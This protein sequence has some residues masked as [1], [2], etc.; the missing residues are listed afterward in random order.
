MKI[1]KIA[2]LAMLAGASAR[3]DELQPNA[4]RTVTVCLEKSA[5]RDTISF[6]RL[7]ASKMFA[8]IG[9]TIQWNLKPDGC[10]AQG[11]LLRLSRSNPGDFHPGTLA[12]TQLDE[13]ARITI[14]YG[15]ISERNDKVPVRTLEAHVL[16]HE[17]THV[18]QATR[19]HSDRGVMK[20]VWDD[21]DFRNMFCKL[22]AF[23]ENDVDMIYRGLA[24]RA[25]RDADGGKSRNGHGSEGIKQ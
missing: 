2:M 5:I 25:G 17:I 3:A 20:A 24:K 6:A 22:L 21:T 1:T 9:V 7:T 8:E 19:G 14:F 18:L 16:A 23:T 13:S 12:Y 4:E 15:R 11:I 10:P